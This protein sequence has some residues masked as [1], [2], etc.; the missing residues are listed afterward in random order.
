M[1]WRRERG[2]CPLGFL[3]RQRRPAEGRSGLGR[4]AATPSQRKR[5]SCQWDSTVHGHVG[6]FARGRDLWAWFT[7]DVTRWVR[8]VL[9]D[10]NGCRADGMEPV[11]G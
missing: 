7:G 1:R 5:A 9:E 8:P 4:V 2:G 6:C 10:P 11:S 3:W